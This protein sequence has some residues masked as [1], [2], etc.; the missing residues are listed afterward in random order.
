MKFYDYRSA[1]SPRKVRLFIAEKGL[2]VPTVEVD[3]RARAQQEPAF[4]AKNAG[5][6]VPVLELDDGT[7]LTESLAICHYL[8]QQRPE[9]NLMGEGAREQAQVLMWN[10]I[11]TFEGYLPLQESLR[12]GHEAFKGRALPGPV[13]WEQIP[14]LA[15]RGRRR[16]A[17]F[18]DKLETRLGE[19]EFVAA[20]RFTYAD[21]VAFVYL[22]FTPR[23]TGLNPI[24]GR[25]AL[26]Q[27][28]EGIAARPAIQ[29]VG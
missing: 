6:T 16:T 27:W 12:N 21:I 9:P 18:L 24:D 23:A 3:L 25:P 22:G 29:R 8:E 4:L 1:P 2:D 5:A 10:D 14:A 13:A 11:L 26:K 7:C 20:K 15:E 28:S 17:L 19:S